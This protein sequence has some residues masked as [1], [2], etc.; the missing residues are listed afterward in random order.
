MLESRHIRVGNSG[1]PWHNPVAGK[2]QTGQG[3]QPGTA[4]QGTLRASHDSQVAQTPSPVG[5][6]P[7]AGTPA[8]LSHP[9]THTDHPSREPPGPPPV[10]RRNST[11]TGQSVSSGP[12]QAELGLD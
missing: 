2:A 12:R 8:T 10:C 1:R 11:Y 9:S 7:P 5:G 3:T 6:I 4:S